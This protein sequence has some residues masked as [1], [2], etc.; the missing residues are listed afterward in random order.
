MSKY[1]D[2]A[3]KK[4]HYTTDSNASHWCISVDTSSSSRN[5]L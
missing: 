4:D 2:L 3:I 5:H 1:N